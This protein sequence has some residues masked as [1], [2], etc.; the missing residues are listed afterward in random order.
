MR[1]DRCSHTFHFDHSNAMIPSIPPTT[2][3]R[4]Y[5]R[6]DLA[7]DMFG[8]FVHFL[9]TRRANPDTGSPEK[10]YATLAWI[11]V[12]DNENVSPPSTFKVLRAEATSLM[13]QLW[14]AGIRPSDIGTPGHLAA[15]Q[16][17]LADMRAI[18]AKNLQV[19]LP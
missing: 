5:T 13:D 15:T 7:I 4:I 14:R 3:E 6:D 18:V 8:D 9:C 11:V 2:V 19:N 10:A 16:A 1:E 17:H 12:P